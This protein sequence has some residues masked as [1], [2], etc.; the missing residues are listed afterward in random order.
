M[1]TVNSKLNKVFLFSSHFRITL[2]FS[3][4]TYVEYLIT[5]FSSDVSILLLENVYLFINSI[6]LNII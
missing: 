3:S 4:H 6:N 1:A 2:I 5:F